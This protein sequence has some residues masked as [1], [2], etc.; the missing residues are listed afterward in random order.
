MT[1]QSYLE[2][3]PHCLD[4]DWHSWIAA[5]GRIVMRP[6][7]GDVVAVI[8]VTPLFVLQ[9]VMLSMTDSAS[10]MASPV[11]FQID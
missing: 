8:L 6:G 3:Q 1:F 9:V 10:L 4:V 11:A 5:V 7:I 2:V